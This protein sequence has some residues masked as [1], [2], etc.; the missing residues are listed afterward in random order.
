MTPAI[1]AERSNATKRYI[2]SM[3]GIAV[4]TKAIR[5]MRTSFLLEMRA[6]MIAPTAGRKS[7]VVK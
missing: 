1:P 4:K 2:A 3:S 7:M 5:L 6:I